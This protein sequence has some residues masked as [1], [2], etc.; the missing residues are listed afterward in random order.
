MLCPCRLMTISKSRTA[1]LRKREKTH[2]STSSVREGLNIFLLLLF[3]WSVC[4]RRELSIT[5]HLAQAR[6]STVSSSASILSDVHLT[7]RQAWAL[8]DALPLQKHV[9]TSWYTQIM[10]DDDLCF[11]LPD[12]A[13]E[14][15][16]DRGNEYYLK[17]I[18]EINQKC[19]DHYGQK[20]AV[21]GSKSTARTSRSILKETLVSHYQAA[22]SLSNVII[23]SIR[24]HIS[25]HMSLVL[26]LGWSMLLY[27]LSTGYLAIVQWR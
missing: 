23:S 9:S 11:P 13:L 15:G 26:W 5:Y 19:W 25:Y 22:I 2:S 14:D 20:R 3:N 12:G 18:F 8:A 4:R 17:H 27:S 24:F 6:H 16:A 7:P 1:H 10:S 21:A